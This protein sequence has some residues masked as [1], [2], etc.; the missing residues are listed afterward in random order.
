MSRLRGLGADAVVSARRETDLAW[1]EALGYHSVLTAKI[2]ASDFD[3]VFNTVPAQV[4]GRTVLE[5][6]KKTAVIVDLASAP[7]GTDF[8]A[9]KE[10]GVEAL[11][12]PSLP[13][14]MF[15]EKAGKILAESAVKILREAGCA[16]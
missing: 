8:D 15:P 12:A 11:T 6:M 13:G 14:R 1:A 5:T 7:Y 4:F 2:D 10:L 9:A 3:V 16:V